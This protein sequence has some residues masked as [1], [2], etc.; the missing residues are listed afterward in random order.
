MVHFDDCKIPAKNLL[1]KE[2]E[3]YKYAISMLNEGRIGIGA[4][5]NFSNKNLLS[6]IFSVIYI[7]RC[8]VFVKVHSIKQFHIQ[9]NENNLVNVYLIFKYIRHIL[10]RRNELVFN[11]LFR[12]CNIK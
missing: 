5:V 9:K 3:G 1:G 10:F 7:N 8:L 12:A 4:Q 11:Y 2:G 6:T